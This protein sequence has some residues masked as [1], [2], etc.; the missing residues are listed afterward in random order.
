MIGTLDI[1][2]FTFPLALEIIATLA[3]AVSG[4][5][6]ARSKRFDFAGVFAMAILSCT[7]GGLIRDGIFLQTIPA[8]LK[9]PAYL[10]AAFLAAAVV[11]MFG[12]LWE[13]LI[14]WD[15]LVQM[16]DAVGTPAFTLI[17]FQ[18]AY[19][20]GVPFIGALFVGLINGVA[21]GILRDV[22]VR[23]IPRFFR[24]GQLFSMILILT[25]AFTLAC[26]MFMW[27][28]IPQR[29]P[30]SSF[31]RPLAGWLSASTGR[32]TPWTSGG[33]SR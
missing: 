18:L 4:S 5:I 22:L 6:V 24:P 20:A 14:W 29:G 7:G 12:R 3:W 2:K 27:T 23:D 33:S 25:L 19:F 31:R 17:G 11:S 9:T 16:I 10:L 1:E 21:G 30:P 8:M 13:R 26:S 28:A 15:A 32:P